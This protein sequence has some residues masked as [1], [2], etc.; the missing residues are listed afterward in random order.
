[1]IADACVRVRACACVRVC[2]G[3][4]EK[5]NFLVWFSRWTAHLYMCVH[6]SVIYIYIN[7]LLFEANV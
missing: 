1:M 3:K 7:K 4:V 5:Q 2:G 6:M